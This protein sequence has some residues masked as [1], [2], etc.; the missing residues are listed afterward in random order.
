MSA[1]AHTVSMEKRRRN[2][3]SSKS[4]LLQIGSG[5]HTFLV[6]RFDRSGLRRRFFASAMTMLGHQ[7]TEDASYLEIGIKSRDSTVGLLER[8]ERKRI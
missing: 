1:R 3:A 7:D 8:D 6:Q 2:R 5:Y 4:R